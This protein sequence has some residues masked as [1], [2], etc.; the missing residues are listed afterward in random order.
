MSLPLTSARALRDGGIDAAA[1]LNEALKAALLDLPVEQHREVKL[2]VGRAMASVL[3]ETV[4]LAIK[5]YPELEPNKETWI[6]VAKACAAKRAE[7]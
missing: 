1:A 5:A 4:D 7:P 2:A 6:L 3:S